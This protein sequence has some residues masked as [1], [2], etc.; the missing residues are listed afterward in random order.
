[1]SAIAY[2]SGMPQP[3]DGL[4]DKIAGV[5]SLAL[6]PGLEFGLEAGS[7]IELC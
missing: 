6:S 7:P 3:R 2:G 4:Y 1:M 5:E